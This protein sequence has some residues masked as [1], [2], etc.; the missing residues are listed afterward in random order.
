MCAH[1]DQQGPP[2]GAL[3]PGIVE[4]SVLSLI[5]RETDPWPERPSAT[6]LRPARDRPRGRA[7]IRPD[8]VG[9]P[10]VGRSRLPA[11]EGISVTAYSLPQLHHIRGASLNCTPGGDADGLPD[12]RVDGRAALLRQAR[13]RAPPRGLACPR[14][15]RADRIS[16]HRRHRAPVFDY[17]CNSCRLA[18]NALSGPRRAF[19]GH[20]SARSPP[21]HALHEPM[22]RVDGLR[23]RA[24]LCWIATIAL[25]SREIVEC[26]STPVGRSLGGHLCSISHRS[27]PPPSAGPDR[28]VD[29]RPRRSRADRC[30]G[31]HQDFLIRPTAGRGR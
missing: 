29:R 21:A 28:R 7:S 25:C 12:R 3:R 23:D 31:R 8:R 13:H 17:R 10:S 1:P 6:L 18:F 16:S 26:D 20:D 11:D 19:S 15:R 2:A 4:R 30:I 22:Q 14:C 5:R 9:L 27:W 24:S